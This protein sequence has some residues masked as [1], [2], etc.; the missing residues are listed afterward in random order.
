MD[1][2]RF[3]RRPER[4]WWIRAPAGCVS[5]RDRLKVGYPWRR[6]EFGCAGAGAV[7]TPTQVPSE[8]IDET[9]WAIPGGLPDVLNNQPMHDGVGPHFKAHKREREHGHGNLQPLGAPFFLSELAPP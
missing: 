2:V 9:G 3:A 4:S 7:R 5:S 8:K 1:R 6:K